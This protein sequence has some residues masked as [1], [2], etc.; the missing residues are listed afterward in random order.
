[1]HQLNKNN[2]LCS[3]SR[4]DVDHMI[5]HTALH[6]AAL[7]DRTIVLVGNDTDL[8][9]MLI[10]KVTP[11]T[12]LH[13]Q[14][15]SNPD[16][17]FS[18]DQIQ[19]SLSVVIKSHLLILHAFTGCDNVSAIYSIDERKAVPV[20]N[21]VP[22]DDLQCLGM[23]KLY[24]AKRASSLDYYRHVM[25]MQRVSRKSLTSDGFLLESV[26]PTSP[27]AKLHSYR[28]YFAVQE[29]LGNDNIIAKDWGWDLFHGRLSPTQ[30]ERAVAPERVLTIVSCGCKVACTK[31]RQC[32]KAG[33][34]CTPMCSSCIGQTCTNF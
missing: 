17:I 3:Q 31:R 2:V 20:L 4:A 27:A 22:S 23:L 29:W 24:G 21:A 13:M 16:V 1:M 34:Y 6:S 26:P 32:R 19:Q 5:A 11:N 14:F 30:T 33:L 8:L 15:S 10:D 25:Y 9:V 18:I 12:K 7:L 28:A